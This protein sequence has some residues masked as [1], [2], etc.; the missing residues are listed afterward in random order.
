M[1]VHGAGTHLKLLEQAPTAPGPGIKVPGL[2]WYQI[3]TEIRTPD[4]VQQNPASSGSNGLACSA[5]C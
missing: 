4:G 3:G 5:T 1:C 2:Y